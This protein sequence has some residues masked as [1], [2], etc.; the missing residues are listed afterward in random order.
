MEFNKIV[1]LL[2]ILIH[3]TSKRDN[4]IKIENYKY[5]YSTV[6]QGGTK[7]FYLNDG[8]DEVWVDLETYLKSNAEEIK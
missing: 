8:K 5:K 7:K 4:P 2:V 1:G 6:T 3:F